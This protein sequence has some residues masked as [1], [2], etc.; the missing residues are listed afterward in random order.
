MRHLVACVTRLVAFF[1]AWMRLIVD[2]REMLEIQRRI[3][4][5]GRDAGVAEQ[6]LHGS[7]V[8]TGLQHMRGE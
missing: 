6:F 5:R 4:L 8:A 1:G 7:K 3:N 2:A